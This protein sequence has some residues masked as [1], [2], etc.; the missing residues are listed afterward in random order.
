MCYQDQPRSTEPRPASRACRNVDRIPEPSWY[1]RYEVRFKAKILKVNN[2]EFQELRV[3]S[4]AKINS[5]WRNWSE[6]GAQVRVIS[7]S[8]G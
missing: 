8:I 6:V 2:E 5:E 7:M 4:A 3:R 1:T